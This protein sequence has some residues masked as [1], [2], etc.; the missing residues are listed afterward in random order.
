MEVAVLKKAH[1]ALVEAAT[2]LLD[3]DAVS[4]A[5]IDQLTAAKRSFDATCSAALHL[6]VSFLCILAVS[7]SPAVV[8]CSLTVRPHSLIP[9]WLCFASS[10]RPK[11]YRERLKVRARSKGFHSSSSDLQAPPSWRRMVPPKA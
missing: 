6:L 5:A 8:R 11:R 1:T 2:T 9:C 10:L 4:V 3:G 7:I